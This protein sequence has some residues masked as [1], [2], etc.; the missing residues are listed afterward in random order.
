MVRA[1]FRN[2]AVVTA[3]LAAAMAVPAAGQKAMS[4]G[5]EFMKAVKDRDGDKVTTALNQPGNTLIGTRDLASGETVLHVV[6]QRRDAV[7]LKFLLAR[8]ANPNVADK[9]G[10]TPL[11]L[12]TNLGFV[13]GIEILLEHGAKIDEA[14]PAGE[15]PLMSA[16][17]RKDIA[18]I[19]L[20][21]ANGADPRRTDN[22]GRSVR[23]YADL[24]GGTVLAEFHK[25]EEDGKNGA[26]KAYGP[27]F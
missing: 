7:W 24:I 19:R 21:L 27:S 12:A 11:V 8:G 17:H 18:M 20:L 9:H 2:T 14:S 1:L 16:V 10:I 4:E 3:L 22:S 5:Y 13:E 25:A 6:A 26:N 23:E 15:T